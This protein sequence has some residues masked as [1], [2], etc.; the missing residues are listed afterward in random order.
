M[1]TV[2]IDIHSSERGFFNLN[3]SDK[4]VVKYL[5]MYRDKI[6]IYYK[7]KTNNHFDNAGNVQKLNQELACL[8][9]NIDDL[10][11][12]CKLSK[13]Q[14]ALLEL[15]SMGMEFKDIAE[16]A[17]MSTA[18]DLESRFETIC[19]RI[20]EMNEWMWKRMIHKKYLDTPHKR[21]SKCKEELPK[22]RY[23]FSPDKSKTD[24]FKSMCKKCR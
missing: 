8:Y 21:C 3:L 11:S 18:Q 16:C 1:G 19:K 14:E 20:A 10:I 9:A 17:N 7:N 5:L 4:N 6:D 15:V 23:F 24:G 2:K 22:I 13:K 12:K